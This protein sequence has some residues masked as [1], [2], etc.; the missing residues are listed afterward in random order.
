MVKFNLKAFRKKHGL[1]QVDIAKLFKC[2]QAN[3]SAIENNADRGLEEYQIEKLKSE[4]GEEAVAGFFVAGNVTNKKPDQTGEY[5]SRYN[6]K[7]DKAAGVESVVISNK[8]LESMIS[9]MKKAVKF[10][11]EMIETLCHELKKEKGKK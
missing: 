5:Q 7:K 11:E 1:R 8:V 2:G 3:I 10:Q 6:T 4:F 9:Q